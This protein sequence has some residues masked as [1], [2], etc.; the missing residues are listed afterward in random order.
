MSNNLNKN[1]LIFNG[2]ELELKTL[3]GS[4]GPSVVDIRTL[5]NDLG[6]FTYD[7]GYGSTG[8]CESA[9]TYIDGEEG[10][11]LHR[12][13]PIDQLADKSSFLEVAYLLLNGELPKKQEKDAGEELVDTAV[14]AGTAIA[15]GIGRGLMSGFNLAKKAAQDRKKRNSSNKNTRK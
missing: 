10:I 13:Y 2:K 5:Y 9:I 14:E 15:K 8:S 11:L 4:V 7:P 6:I 1:K 12:G 3:S